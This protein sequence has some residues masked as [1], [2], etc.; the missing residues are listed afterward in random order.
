[1]PKNRK[2]RILSACVG[3][4]LFLGLLLFSVVLFA[5]EDYYELQVDREGEGFVFP[6]TGSLLFVPGTTVNLSA[7]PLADT[8]QGF[9]CWSGD[10]GGTDDAVTVT[11]DRHKKV[12]AVFGEEPAAGQEFKTLTIA[13]SGAGRGTTQPGPGMY[14]H[15]SGKEVLVQALPGEGGYFEGWQVIF[16]ERELSVVPDSFHRY[17]LSMDED[18]VLVARF[19]SRGYDV[20]LETEGSGIIVPGPGRYAVAEGIAMEVKAFPDPGH[21]LL[22]WDNGAGVVLQ[23][24]EDELNV[25]VLKIEGASGTYRAVFEKAERRIRVHR[26]THGDAK[27]RVIPESISEKA[28]HSVAYGQVVELHALPENDRTAFAGWTG[29]LP[30]SFSNTQ[31]LSPSLQLVMMEDRDISA[32]FI[33]AETALN[34]ELSVDGRQDERAASLLTPAPGRYGF[35]RNEA[36]GMEV[37]AALAQGQPLA[38]TRWEGDLPEGAD[39]EEYTLFLPMDRDRHVAAR[40]TEREALSMQVLHTGDGRGITSPQPGRYTVSPGRVLVLEAIPHPENAFGGWRMRHPGEPDRLILDNP[41]QWPLHQAVEIE[42]FFGSTPCAVSI[43]ATDTKAEIRPPC[44]EY[45]L[46]K[47]A[48]IV[49][50]A[51]P[52]AGTGFHHWESSRSE[53]VSETPLTRVKITGDEGYRAVF[54]PPFCALRLVTA[55][56]GTGTVEA[57]VGRLDRIVEGASVRLVAHAAPDAVFSHWEGNFPEET[58]VTLPE[59]I[60]V[61]DASKGVTAHFDRADYQLTVTAAGLGNTEVATLQ[62]GVGVSGYRGGSRVRLAAFPPE[63]SAVAFLG[64]TGDITSPNPEHSLVM[65]KSR[66]VTAVFGPAARP[67]TAVLNLM[68]PVGTGRGRTHPLAPGKYSFVEGAEIL[69]SFHLAEEDYFGGWSQ[70]YEGDIRYFSLPVR[71]DGDKTLG[72]HTA[73]AGSTLVLMLDTAEAGVTQPPPGVYRLADGMKVTLNAIRTDDD[74]VFLGWHAPGGNLLSSRARYTVTVS[75]ASP[76]T[77]LIAVF[78]PYAAPPELVLCNYFGGIR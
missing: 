32:A 71:M 6:D 24:P 73:A 64:W 4:V 19:H 37:R 60:V 31:C 22:H 35:V 47:G 55:G 66:Q 2:Y 28:E 12:T 15:L 57:D 33:E 8:N 41:L 13:V 21:R 27:G 40:F 70:N 67:G 17:G 52:A 77:E 3:F 74:Y 38:F 48:D 61:M 25:H 75:S 20:A 65:D 36:A 1:V 34:L 51:V 78:R 43:S 18:V 30:E 39:P 76:R 45:R 63:G 16:P 5:P 62:P 11:M 10:A 68:P 72:P 58:N 44:G 69:L 7:E 56:E 50:E 29:D 59:I 54:G 14:R 26:V 49:L 42:A 46:A 23:E 53:I 9:V